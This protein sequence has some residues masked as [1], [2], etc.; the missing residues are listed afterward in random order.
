MAAVGCM[1]EKGCIKVAQPLLDVVT[2]RTT[3]MR[4]VLATSSILASPQADALGAIVVVFRFAFAKGRNCLT[5]ELLQCANVPQSNATRVGFNQSALLKFKQEGAQVLDV[6]TEV[7]SS[8][9]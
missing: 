9:H 1:A 3:A 6:Q 2:R 5:G 8:K 4:P 7:A